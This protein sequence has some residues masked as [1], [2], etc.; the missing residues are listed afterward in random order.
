MDKLKKKS[1]I[2]FI[3]GIVV[4]T[5]LVLL[6][7]FGVSVA[8][9]NK[10]SA[11]N[12]ILGL[13]LKG[14][15]SITY[16]AKGDFTDEDFQD[17][18][19][20]LKLRADEF[21]AESDVYQ[22]GKDRITVEIPGEKDAEAVLEKLGKPGSLS[23]VTDFGAENAKTWISGSDIKS[24]E[25]QAQ[26]SSS[27]GATEY[28]VAFKLNESAVETFSNVTKEYSGKILYVVYDGQAISSPSINTQISSGEG[29]ITGMDSLEEAEELAS[30]IRIGSLKVELESLTSKVVSAKL[31]DDAL[32]TSITAGLIGLLIISLFMIFVYR[33]PGLAAA[34]SM[35]V[36]TALNL[37]ALNGFDMT[38][39]LPGIA[40]VIL[41]IGMAVDANVII[42]AR[43]KEEVAVN[44]NIKEAIN[45]G[46]KRA[47]SAIVDGNITTII[48]ALVLMV[49]GTG[50]I[51]GFAQTLIIGIILSMINAL[52]ISRIIVN[53]LYGM[54]FKAE[55]YYGKHTERKVFDFLKHRFVFMGISLLIIASGFVVMI[56]SN[57]GKISSRQDILNYSIEFQG[58]VS[59]TVEFE[60]NYDIAYFNENIKK[61]IAK[62]I[63]DED[64]VANA[65]T[66]SNQYVIK[67]KDL[68]AAKKTEVKE[69]LVTKYKAIKDS[70]EEVN[71]SATTSSEMRTDAIISVIIALILI[72][73]YIFIRFKNLGFATAA[74]I[75]LFHDVVIV[76]MYYVF[77]WT[78]VGNTF[79]ACMLT[80]VGYSINSTIVI[81]D[82]IRE[83]IKMSGEN[84]D[85]KE[86]INKSITQT[87][88]RSIY[89]TLTTFVMVFALYILG[90]TAIKEF[91]M[92]LIVGVLAG[93]YGSVCLTGA[94]W[95]M[96]SNKKN[97][98]NNK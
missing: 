1:I 69:M 12:I 65:V 37:L 94:L 56:L 77:S 74:I 50:T 6:T 27:T 9:K 63:D 14:G 79:I 13:D 73:I 75:A 7:V 40:G 91:A 95:Y 93:C 21:S 86:I 81:F 48:S 78:S 59:T 23:F 29:V 88:T 62:I 98:K 54:G 4:T 3:L 38:L 42:Y 18:I 30:V 44:S 76:F 43:I 22:E 66:G 32:S 35:I 84:Y 90:V 67:T 58:G 51:K 70:I 28:V 89:T 11:K 20:K 96:M 8:G 36:Y 39:T 16:Q 26:K 41:S 53:L 47:T 80:I 19:K 31:G 57:S 92:P 97:K 82:R 52:V 5:L 60:K 10:G 2:L 24:A 34:I 61:D 85:K 71:V 64:V 17:T 68:S 49:M 25:G 83:N 45:H 33:I 15:V 87:L 46:F 55:K 72:L